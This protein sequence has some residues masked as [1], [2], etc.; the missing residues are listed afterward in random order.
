MKKQF[1]LGSVLC[2]LLLSICSLNGYAQTYEE[3]R[4]ALLEEQEKKRAEINVL[5][6]RIKQF[7]QRVSKTENR[8]DKSYKKYKNLTNLIALQDDKIGSLQSEQ[9]RIQDEVNLIG[10]ELNTRE[11]ELNK[12]IENYKDIILYA[13]KNGRTSNLELLFTSSSI[14]QMLVRS[15]YLQKFEEQKAKQANQIKKRKQELDLMKDD[16]EDSHKKNQVI[17]DE[18]R[19]EKD[20]LGNQRQQQQRIVEN[21]KQERSEYLAELRKTREKKES[22]EN[23][24][25]DLIAKYEKLRKAENERLAKLEAARNIA[26]SDRRAEEVAK[27]SKPIVRENYLDEETLLTYE[28]AFSRSRGSLPWPVNSTTIAKKFGRYRNPLYGTFTEH[29]GID[30]V[31]E[32]GSDVQVV[33]DGR[34]FSIVP[35]VGF[36]TVV[37]VQHGSYY[38]AYGNLSEINVQN[39]SLLERGDLIGKS[40]TSA[41]EMGEVLFFMVRKGNQ[42]L[43]PVQWL[44]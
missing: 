28:T 3:K 31:A 20:Q 17:L 8:Y 43:N 5:E 7:Q 1:I 26:D 35:I 34:V 42:N 40:G 12:L 39:F 18:I 32:P 24:F 19:Q 33:A 27:Y 4:K 2:A 9:Q 30:I 44:D 37:F 25:A 15:Y 41:S 38:T 29:P 21:I 14:N 23:T 22:L 36:G 13:Y 16:L 6:A 11:K 10:E